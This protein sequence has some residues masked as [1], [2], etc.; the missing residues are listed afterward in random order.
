MIR[1]RWLMALG[2]AVYLLAL[3][4]LTPARLAFDPGLG[5]FPETPAWGLSGVRGTL[6][7]GR[8]RLQIQG[9]DLG[10]VRWRLRP[11]ALLGARLGFDL[12]LED[13]G[14][15]VRAA[16]R[17][18]L[19]QELEFRRLE[20]YLP[21][22]AIRSWTPAG[23][24]AVLDGRLRLDIQRMTVAGSSLIQAEGRLILDKAVLRGASALPLGGFELRLETRPDGVIRGRLADTGEGPLRVSGELAGNPPHRYRIDL[25]LVAA[26]Q[27]PQ[28]A[29]WL[30]AL[31]EPAADG[32]VRLLFQRPD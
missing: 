30:S 27:A 1:G 32:S 22:S 24:A 20:G 5:V 17:L 4:A 9:Q 23:L 19:D 29:P 15:S 16:A 31:G 10:P 14:A 8:A 7:N 3:A 25:T 12:A 2:L 26:P 18:G 6:I 28:L 21:L 11:G 13:Q